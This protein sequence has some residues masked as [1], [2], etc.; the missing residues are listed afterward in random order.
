MDFSP[1]IGQ[2]SLMARWKHRDARDTHHT[3][4]A[5]ILDALG[6]GFLI[7]TASVLAGLW[8]GTAQLT[9]GLWA[10]GVAATS[11]VG[12][13][14]GSALIRN[15]KCDRCEKRAGGSPRAI[16]VRKFLAGMEAAEGIAPE[17]D[18][19]RRRLMSSRQ[20]EQST[21]AGRGA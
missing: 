5:G 18:R 16:E 20:R 11:G 10:I 13:M 15:A 8:F 3:V 19:A 9:I 12:C 7:A 1:L 14:I 17:D 4:S 6:L 21:G 2:W